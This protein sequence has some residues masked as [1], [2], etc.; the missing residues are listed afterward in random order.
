VTSKD[1]RL[2]YN[3]SE[4]YGPTSLRRALATYFSIST[5]TASLE[6]LYVGYRVRTYRTGGEVLSRCLP[7]KESG[8]REKLIVRTSNITMPRIKHYN[9]LCSSK[10]DHQRGHGIR[11]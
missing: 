4:A 9:I 5:S 11:H 8:R 3:I 6:R 10:N 1:I 2:P 7:A